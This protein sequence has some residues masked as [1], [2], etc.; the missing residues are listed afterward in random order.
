[1]VP[2]V[3]AGVCSSVRASV[4]PVE[5]FHL[6]CCGAWEGKIAGGSGNQVKG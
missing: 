1:V 6:M 4:H 5:R 3:T 2:A